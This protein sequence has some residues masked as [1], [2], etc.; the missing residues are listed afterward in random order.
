MNRSE[1]E[2]GQ[3]G[4]GGGAQYVANEALARIKELGG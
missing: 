1:W 2:W 3:M 4:D